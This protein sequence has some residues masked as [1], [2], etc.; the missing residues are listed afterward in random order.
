[1]ALPRRILLRIVVTSAILLIIGSLW[2]VKNRG[3]TPVPALVRVPARE[4]SVPGVDAK[5]VIEPV[6]APVVV[7]PVS[8][9]SPLPNPDFFLE[10]TETIDLARLKSYGLPLVIDFGA[11]SCAPCKE[12][13]PVLS[14]LNA[15][16]QGKAI[17]RFV[18]VWKD[19]KLGEGFPLRVIP[20][21]FFFDSEGRPFRPS[22]PDA[23]RML[24]YVDEDT[25][26]HV[27]TAHEGGMT[28]EMILQTL[29][30][31]GLSHD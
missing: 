11:D 28:E 19:Q 22:D 29:E 10:V 27:F 12:M 21:Q 16:L 4:V 3:E 20:T 24:M 15:R 25:E 9:E 7:E 26:E 30:E 8:V 18:D 5:G 13:A 6:D 31:M 23:S 14:D 1:M 17:I 2:Y